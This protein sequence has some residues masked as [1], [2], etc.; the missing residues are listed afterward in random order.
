VED[1]HVG[2]NLFKASRF[3]TISDKCHMIDV[4]DGLVRET[5]SN[6]E[7]GDP[8]EH[9]MLNDSSTKDANPKVAIYAQISEA[10]P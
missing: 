4:V 2:F 9:C 5:I 10:S 3:P 1:D 8:L 6:H 7:S